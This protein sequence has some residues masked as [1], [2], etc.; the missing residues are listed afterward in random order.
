MNYIVQISGVY[1][2]K[3]VSR[4]SVANGLTG[5]KPYIFKEAVHF[6]KQSSINK[7]INKPIPL[8]FL[9][10]YVEYEYSPVGY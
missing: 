3:H 9:K 7:P 4:N 8:Y 6:P 1:I 10:T 5:R 2:I